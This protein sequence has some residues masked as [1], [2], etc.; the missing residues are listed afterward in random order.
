MAIRDEEEL[1]VFDLDGIR[2][3]ADD[4]VAG[5]R[6]YAESLGEGEDPEA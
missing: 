4:I 2:E 1:V 5:L 3:M 6:R